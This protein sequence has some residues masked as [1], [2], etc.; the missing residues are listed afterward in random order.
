M[1]GIGWILLTC[2]KGAFHML[3]VSDHELGNV[4]MP[5]V[6]AVDMWEHAYMTDYA[7]ADKLNYVDAYLAAVNWK[8]VEEA[9]NSCCEGA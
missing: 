4:S 1:R 2:D 8:K 5:A 7:P 9:F 6:L 3:W